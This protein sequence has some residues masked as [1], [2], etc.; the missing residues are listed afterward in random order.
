MFSSINGR[1]R[2]YF[3][4]EG[5]IRTTSYKYK[6]ND[7]SPAIH[8]TNDAVQ[9]YCKDYG[10]YEKGNKLSYEEFDRYLQETNEFG[11]QEK[12]SFFTHILPQIKKIS[13]DIS[14]AAYYFVDPKKKMNNF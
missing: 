4:Q 14:H 8:L 3:Y 7:N 12:I 1:M 9:K 2:G 10:K 13:Q 6:L 5:Y 11:Q